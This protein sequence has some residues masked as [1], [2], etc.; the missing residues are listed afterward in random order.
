M[1]VRNEGR[2]LERSLGAVLQQDYPAPRLEVLVVDGMSTDG[3]RALVEASRGGAVPVRLLDN[4]AR[5]APTALNIGLSQARGDII[6]RVDGHCEVD[7]DFVREAVAGLARTGADCVGGPLETVGEGYVGR[8]IAIGVSHPMG[9]GNAS[10]RIGSSDERVVDTVAFGAY[11]RDVFDRI[12]R[13]DEALVR[14]QDDEFNLRL[15]RAGGR[16]VL[17]PRMRCRYCSRASLAR[18]WRQY[19]QYGYWKV[20]VQRK[21]GVVAAWRHLVP[22]ALVL[23][24]LMATVAAIGLGAI[25]P[26]AL[27][28]IP[29]GLALFLGAVHAARRVPAW[30]VLP[31][32]P[33]VFLTLHL[34]YGL[35]LLAA[36]IRGGGPAADRARLDAR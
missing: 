19:W 18:L 8:A 34:S 14:N 31:L 36:L 2:F 13:F 28:L 15:C 16:I 30:D 20:R 32:L 6:I 29:Y 12:G 23:S 4:P 3:S 17:T 33:I 10:F 22:S 11:R 9:V 26:L 25:W 24:L 7:P 21:H 1:P 27:V 5:I 35:G